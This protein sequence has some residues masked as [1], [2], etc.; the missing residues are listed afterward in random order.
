MDVIT[1]QAAASAGHSSHLGSHEEDT[2]YLQRL[3]IGWVSK[4]Q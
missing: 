3:F 4:E 1:P 2:S